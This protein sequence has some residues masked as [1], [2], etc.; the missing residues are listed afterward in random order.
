[1]DKNYKPST[2]ADPV[3][4][5]GNQVKKFKFY[6]VFITKILGRSPTFEVGIFCLGNPGS[7]TDQRINCTEQSLP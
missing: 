7:A 3:G 4:R 6:P 1:M 5:E 2:L